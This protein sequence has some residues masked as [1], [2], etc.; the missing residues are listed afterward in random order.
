MARQLNLYVSKEH[1]YLFVFERFSLNL[2]NTPGGHEFIL[3]FQ[4]F[5]NRFPIINFI[6][7]ATFLIP[8]IN[9]NC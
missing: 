4:I 7:F 2:L 8:S 1:I 3:L 9:I 5:Q 6:Y